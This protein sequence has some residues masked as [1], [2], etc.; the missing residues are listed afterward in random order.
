MPA[1]S[2]VKKRF[3]FNPRTRY[4]TILASPQRLASLLP[5]NAS[6]ADVK[7]TMRFLARAS[8]KEVADR[9]ARLRREKQDEAA[10]RK[11]AEDDVRR[12]SRDARTYQRARKRDQLF[13]TSDI[14]RFK[15]NPPDNYT[16]VVHSF[17]GL[18]AILSGVY[19]QVVNDEEDGF[20]VQFS[21]NGRQSEI[22][23]LSRAWL[24]YLVQTQKINPNV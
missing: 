6:I 4:K 19:M 18:K 12:G 20:L 3:V 13:L 7:T 16:W 11:V 14:D 2:D 17:E 21:R 9:R 8:P 23:T 10:A 1:L 22:R 24:T 5:T 15:N